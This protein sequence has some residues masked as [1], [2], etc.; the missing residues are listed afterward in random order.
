[1]FSTAE[2]VPYNT[3]GDNVLLMIPNPNLRPLFEFFSTTVLE[4]PSTGKGL[5]GRLLCSQANTILR[6]PGAFSMSL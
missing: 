1:M 6:L 3:S 4:P 5:S 2:E